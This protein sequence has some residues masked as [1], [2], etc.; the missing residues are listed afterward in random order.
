MNTLE[1]VAVVAGSVGLPAAITAVFG[2]WAGQIASG[3]R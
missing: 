1:W 2:W 3:K